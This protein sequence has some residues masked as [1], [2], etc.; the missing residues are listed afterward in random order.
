LET[1]YLATLNIKSEWDTSLRNKSKVYELCRD[2]YYKL[3]DVRI[4]GEP[5][6]FVERDMI[7]ESRQ[8]I[9]DELRVLMYNE[10][11]NIEDL[12]KIMTSLHN[13]GNKLIRIDVI[14]HSKLAV[15]NIIM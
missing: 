14:N 1:Q 10:N 6:G 8:E 11:A 5:I 7:Y 13:W 15:C 2:I 12:S 4:N 9:L 3:Y